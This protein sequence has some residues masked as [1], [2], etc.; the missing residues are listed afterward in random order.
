MNNKNTNKTTF[1][2][3]IQNKLT[4]EE[5]ERLEALDAECGNS[6]EY[7]NAIDNLDCS[8]K[9]KRV[10]RE[11]SA[12]T[13]EIGG[14]TV[15]IGRIVLDFA[16]K[17]VVEV[18]RRFPHVS[19]A[20]LLLLILKAVLA[21]IPFIGWILAPLLEPLFLVVFVG[22]GLVKDVCN[23]V[24]PMAARHYNVAPTTAQ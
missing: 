9:I 23:M 14:K 19:C 4:R 12:K 2:A 8:A 10:L 18:Y 15:R 16:F 3:E 7:E 1:D 21:C 24:A 6:G 17:T 13:V 11:L 20:I 22:V 5:R